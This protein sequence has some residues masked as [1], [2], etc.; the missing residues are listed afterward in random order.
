MAQDEKH[1]SVVYQQSGLNLNDPKGDGLLLWAMHELIFT[2]VPAY[3]KAN[4]QGKGEETAIAY[5]KLKD[6]AY[7]KFPQYVPH[8][9][10]K[11]LLVPDYE[12]KNLDH[13]PIAM[14]GKVSPIHTDQM[15]LMMKQVIAEEAASGIEPKLG[16]VHRWS[17]EA[18]RLLKKKYKFIGRFNKLLLV[19]S[20]GS[21]SRFLV[22][23][24]EE[25]L[26]DYILTR[27]MRSINLEEM[28]RA[29]YRINEGDIYLSFLT[30][31]N[32][33]S[34]FWITLERDKRAITTRLKDVTNYNYSTDKFGAW[35]HYYGMMLYGYVYGVF[36]AKT[37]ALVG[38]LTDKM[39]T[40]ILSDKQEDSINLKG[41][42]IGSEIKK[43]VESK[44]Y[45][46]FPSYSEHLKEDSYMNLNEDFSKR[47]EKAKAK[48]EKKS[49]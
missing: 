9:E 36:N 27:P 19:L 43:F 30:V 49:K 3:T 10:K 47:L 21:S 29:S 18:R 41:A 23:G 35:Y 42:K 37:V 24:K 2:Q 7:I 14:D 4:F 22:T 38:S 6:E 28:F 1:E 15:I 31:E 20:K 8:I 48:A 13:Y 17:P 16:T 39:I 33:L 45:L 32:I 26:T 40:G 25:A 44:E 34:K 46:S 5:Q 11:N 12:P